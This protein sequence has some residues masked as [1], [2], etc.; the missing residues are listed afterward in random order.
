MVKAFHGTSKLLDIVKTGVVLCPGLVGL[1]EEYMNREKWA[2]NFHEKMMDWYSECVK[3]AADFVREHPERLQRA[4]DFDGLTDEAIS[5]EFISE[6][7]LYVADGSS[8]LH[9]ELLELR[10]NSHVFLASD[11]RLALSYMY[12]KGVVQD[13]DFGGVIELDLPQEVVSPSKLGL[14]LV[15]TEVPLKYA[16]N[17]YTDSNHMEEIGEALV[18][19]GNSPVVRGLKERSEVFA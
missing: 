6:F 9:G 11:Y 1:K 4:V 8:D 18:G 12:P 19:E 14:V 5:D 3:R 10:R 15:K 16:T 17:I 2:M 13:F 7:P